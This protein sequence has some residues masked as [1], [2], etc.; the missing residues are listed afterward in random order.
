MLNQGE[1]ACAHTRLPINCAVAVGRAD[2]QMVVGQNEGEVRIAP[3]QF[4]DHA[5]FTVGFDRCHTA[6]LT[7]GCGF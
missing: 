6:Q 7:F 5:V 1:S 3:G 4:N 2:Q